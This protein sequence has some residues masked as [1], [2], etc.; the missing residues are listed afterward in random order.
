[1]D[2]TIRPASVSDIPEI[3]RQRRGMY[4][5]MG[6]RDAHDLDQMIATCRPYFEKSIPDGTFRAWLA[7]ANGRTVGGGAVVITMRPC[8]PYDYDQDCRQAGIL[9]VYVD[10]E[11][12]R[13]GIA[14][15]LM[16]TMIAWCRDQ[17]FHRVTLHASRDGK[18][19]YE[20]MGFTP[21][22][23]MELK[24]RSSE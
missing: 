10:A 11:F 2:L 15:R 7:S 20:S 8:H 16:E 21:T 13:Q 24:L 1:M 3:L 19:L 23:E 6:F 9:N 18:P 12:R 22:S 5:A 14:R 4:E 17:K